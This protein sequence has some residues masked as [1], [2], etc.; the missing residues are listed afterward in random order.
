MLLV[1]CIPFGLQMID[2]LAS[3]QQEAGTL[4]VDFFRKRASP[5]WKT[6]DLVN[7]LSNASL[8]VD[9]KVKSE[10]SSAEHELSL[11]DKT[12][13]DDTGIKITM[14]F[15]EKHISHNPIR[16]SRKYTSFLCS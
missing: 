5:S 7:D 4:S 6:D 14:T 9:D 10:N 15:F 2:A 8:D 11:T 1:L 16:Y 3:S 12:P 13:K